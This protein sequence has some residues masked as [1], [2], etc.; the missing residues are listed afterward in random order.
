MSGYVKSAF[1]VH[2]EEGAQY[3]EA[4]VNNLHDVQVTSVSIEDFIELGERLIEPGSHVVVAADLS[5]IKQVMQFTIDHNLTMGLLPL[6]EQQTLRKS[7]LLPK[8]VGEMVSL[9]LCDESIELDIVYCNDRLLLF[10]GTVGRI[11]LIDNLSNT[12]KWSIL[13]DGLKKVNALKLLPFEI[14]SEGKSVTTVKTAASGCMIL[15]HSEKSYASAMI[16]HNTSRMD[17]LISTVIVAPISV[18]D[19]LK[20]MWTRILFSGDSNR[21]PASIG[22]IKSPQLTIDSDS[23]LNFNI[24]GE[25]LTTLPVHIEVKPAALKLNFKPEDGE[26]RSSAGGDR[27]EKFVTSSLPAGKELSKA[28]NRKVPFFTYASEERFKDLFIALREDASLNSQYVVLML[29]STVL[30]TVGLYLNSA[31]VIIGAM[32]LA[33]LMAPIISLAMGLLRHDQKLFKKSVYKII[34]GVFLALTASAML[35]LISPYQPFTGEMGARINPTVLDL[36]VAIAAGVAGA[37]TKSFKEILQSLAGVAIAVAL[38]PPLAVAG[39]GLGRFDFYIF[40][41]AFLLFSTN[42]IGI[43]VAAALTFR[44]LGY[45]S[46][47]HNK[48][49]ISIVIFFLLAICVPLFVSFEGIVE[50]SSFESSWEKDRFLV[51][52]KYLIVHKTKMNKIQNSKILDIQI[53]AREQLNRSDLNEFRRKIKRNFGDDIVIRAQVSYIL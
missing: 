18:L 31:S 39:V 28:R 4:V 22:F 46:A 27:T 10:K 53:H 11:P 48:R 41:E 16:G 38:V 36:T 49:G 6:P 24:D 45:S 42:L 3:R 32:L 52:G 26:E 9:S 17:G 7:Y 40:S 50:R 15:E 44:L 21:V 19:Y 20:L 51:N 37:Y 35:T 30:A 23:P 8:D 2:N 5:A 13:I 47:V 33:P 14:T 1:F 25:D 34:F 43:V 29:L 12:S